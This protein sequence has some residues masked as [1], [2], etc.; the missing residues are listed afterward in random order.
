MP[1]YKRYIAPSVAEAKR[2]MVQEMGTRAHIVK[3]NKKEK[4]SF[5]GLR[6]EVFFEVLAGLFDE[7]KLGKKEEEE[8][9]AL[10]KK[11]PLGFLEAVI[12]NQ[13]E[14]EASRQSDEAERMKKM[15]KLAQTIRSKKASMSMEQNAAPESREPSVKEQNRP[16]IEIEPANRL[17]RE[18]AVQ[19]K[20]RDGV[21]SFLE[22]MDFHSSFIESLDCDIKNFDPLSTED[23]KQV[24]NAIVRK[25]R[26]SDEIAI[27]A[28]TPNIV[29]VVGP[30]GVGKTTTLAKIAGKYRIQ[31]DRDVVLAS[32]DYHRV[33]ATAQLEKYA[34][35]LETSFRVIYDKSELK[36]LINDYIN[37]NLIFIDTSGTSPAEDE[38]LAELV[39]FIHHVEIPK[40]THFCLSASLR[41]R[42]MKWVL[43]TFSPARADRVI[44]TKIDESQ[45]LGTALSLVSEQELKLSY[46]TCGQDVPYDIFPATEEN[47]RAQLLKEWKA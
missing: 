30:T 22:D 19:T 10:E 41:R 37:K 11:P 7:S 26:F 8:P 38:R 13:E 20:A 3:I 42:E 47:I 46:L 34:S 2:Q 31:E 25:L 35:I 21:Y 17:E 28:T 24:A 27:Y 43:D 1:K 45:S 33:L 5:F 23:Q 9:I 39:E 15:E 18:T 40:E 6:K 29:F 16:R 44:L 14:L 12:K 4:K 32:F 36:K